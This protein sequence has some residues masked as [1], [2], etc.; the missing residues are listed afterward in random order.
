MDNLFVRA[1]LANRLERKEHQEKHAEIRSLMLR[2][3]KL[4][5]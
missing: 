1:L 4:K 5:S 3:D 2:L